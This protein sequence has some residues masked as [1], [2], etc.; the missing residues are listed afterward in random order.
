MLYFILLI[1]YSHRKP[2]SLSYMPILEKTNLEVIAGADDL[3][4]EALLAGATGWIAGLTNI[5][6]KESVELYDL[7]MA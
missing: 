5:S 2:K 6:P 3:A 1:K 4:L 7:A